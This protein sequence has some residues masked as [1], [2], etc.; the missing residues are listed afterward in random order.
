MLA[1][2]LA[3]LGVSEQVRY[4]YIIKKR[5]G[6]HQVWIIILFLHSYTM[7]RILIVDKYETFLHNSPS[8]LKLKIDSFFK[9]QERKKKNWQ[10][11]SP[12]SRNKANS[13]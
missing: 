11:S 1:I 13:S 12:T 6:M 5:D 9:V 3:I 8:L 4:N 10:I 7:H 2:F